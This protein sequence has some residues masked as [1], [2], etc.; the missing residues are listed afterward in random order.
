M[1]RWLKIL[2]WLGASVSALWLGLNVPAHFRSVSPRVL[3]AAGEG[4]RQV[5]D[6][7]KRY[8]DAGRTGPAQLLWNSM[9]DASPPAE[10]VAI[11]EALREQDPLLVYTGGSA[12]YWQAFIQNA[13]R[14]NPSSPQV[15]AVLLP[16]EN[17]EWLLGFLEQSTNRTVQ[18]L[19]ATRE[20]TGWQLF[21]PVFSASG[22][23][24]DATIL[25]VAL[26]E[27]GQSFANELADTLRVVA[28]RAANGD[29]RAL[30]E[31][32]AIYAAVLTLARRSDWNQLSAWVAFASD[33]EELMRISMW[34]QND[35]EG[36]ARL[37]AALTL[38]GDP[39]ALLRY[40]ERHGESGWAGVQTA[41]P[42]G[43]GAIQGMLRLEQPLYQRPAFL[44]DLP[45]YFFSGEDHF[46]GF[47][48]AFP[49]FALCFRVALFSFAGFA[50]F[51]IFNI[52]GRHP[53]RGTG[54][55]RRRLLRLDHAIGGVLL[56]LLIWI[57]VEPNLLRFEP[58][59]E[60]TL[61]LNIASLSPLS[62]NDDT[63]TQ[64]K[65]MDQ[66]TLLILVFF[67]VVQLMVFVFALLRM[68][69]I[70]KQAVAVDTKLKLLDNEEN[71]FDL[72]LYVGLFGTVSALILVV[73][74]IVEASLMAAYA[75]TLFGIL[76]V[77]ILKVGFLRP[78]RQRLI[79]Q[80]RSS[81]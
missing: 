31:L 15:A 6:W 10:D 27:Q 24:L 30:R 41:M 71:L 20:L 51:S 62:T 3:E 7:A 21:L 29:E 26:L 69:E 39:G 49:A 23:P 2:L 73:L 12:P 34:V 45:E 42:L 28:G 56:A 11:F 53:K 32:E 79:L 77:A 63:T 44:E 68:Q 16:R 75:S 48:E 61:Q 60:G 74:N 57:L 25:T 65:P 36:S 35:P 59:R 5:H 80:T 50:F 37:F 19:L 17:R 1:I 8:L 38:S 54:R 22:Q 76:F 18:E 4:S 55:I 47:V 81:Q 52:G 64:E 67:F 78:L 40:L 66:V 13:P 33:T 43:T 9:P 46:K 70:R 72:G 58:N 14:L